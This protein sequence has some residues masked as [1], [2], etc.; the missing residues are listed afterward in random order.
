MQTASLNAQTR[1]GRGKGAARQLRRIGR[2]PAVLYGHGEAPR[3]LSIDAHELEKLLARISVANTL[4]DLAIEGGETTRALIREVQSHPFRPEVLH[5]DLFHVHAGEK[6]HLKIPV[7][8]TGTPNGVRLGGGVLDQVL[9]ELEVECLPGDIPDTI[10]VDVTGL[11]AGDSVRVADI[12]LPARA[13]VLNDTDL[14]V[15]SVVP[16]TVPVLPETAVGDTGPGDAVEPE[17]IR[18]RAT[19]SPDEIPDTA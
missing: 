11:E 1:T 19:A 8:L 13:R 2:V 12:P 4:I 5:L 14:P 6:I 18:G 7:R 9:Y 10:E 16:P 15:A 17:L 3:E